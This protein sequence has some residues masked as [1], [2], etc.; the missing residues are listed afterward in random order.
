MIKKKSTKIIFTSLSALMILSGSSYSF[1]A[2]NLDNNSNYLNQNQRAHVNGPTS[3]KS[4][5]GKTYQNYTSAGTGSAARRIYGSCMIKSLSGQVPSGYMGTHVN[6]YN[7]NTGRVVSTADWYYNSSPLVGFSRLT[8]YYSSSGSYYTK[9]TNHL[10]NAGSYTPFSAV[11]SPRVTASSF[12]LNIS[13]KE[14]TEREDLYESKNMIAAVGMNNVEGY[15]SIDDLYGDIP[16]NPDEALA[17]QRKRQK[18]DLQYRLIPLYDTDGETI[19]GD[20]KIDYNFDS[21]EII[22]E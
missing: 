8:D 10:Y 2:N 22:K 4:V 15:I 18:S 19:I 13:E 5:Y 16:Q 17:M 1:A 20:Y 21:I 7:S 3:K 14:L 9:A 12:K 11:P 6:L